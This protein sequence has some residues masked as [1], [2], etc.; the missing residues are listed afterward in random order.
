MEENISHDS[1]SPKY[2]LEETADISTHGFPAKWR[3]S[4]EIPYWRHVTTQIWVVLPIG[5]AA[6]EIWFN[7]SGALPR[8]VNNT[9]S[10]LNFYARFLLAQFTSSSFLTLILHVLFKQNE[11][12]E[13]IMDAKSN[14]FQPVSQRMTYTCMRSFL[15]TLH[16]LLDKKPEVHSTFWLWG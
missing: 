9:S 1:V 4:V 11:L 6:W 10:A 12:D 5:R 8:S 3:L 2:R 7:Q 15:Y 16:R 13:R 14:I